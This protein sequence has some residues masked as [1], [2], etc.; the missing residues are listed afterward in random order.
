MTPESFFRADDILSEARSAVTRG[1]LARGL[2]AMQIIGKLETMRIVF[3]ELKEMTPG[4]VQPELTNPER[5]QLTDEEASMVDRI[6][7]IH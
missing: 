3:A 6:T 1:P 4:Q 7:S 5:L 2:D